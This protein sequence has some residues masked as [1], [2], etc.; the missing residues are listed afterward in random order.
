MIVLLELFVCTNYDVMVFKS[1]V[2]Y[3]LGFSNGM[4]ALVTLIV[5]LSYLILKRIYFS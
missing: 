4:S 2:T 3:F 1:T 5:S